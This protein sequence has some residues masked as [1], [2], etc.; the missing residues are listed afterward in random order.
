[1]G[2]ATPEEYEAAAARVPSDSDTQSAV[3]SDLS[4]I[5]YNHRTNEYVV[6]SAAGYIVTYYLP[7]DG[8]TYWLQKLSEIQ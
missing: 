1:M 6:V 4:K 2:F 7:L 8:Q 3:R 5:H